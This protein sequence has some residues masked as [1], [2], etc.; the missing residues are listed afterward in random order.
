MKPENKQA[1]PNQNEFNRD[2]S[3]QQPSSPTSK[4]GWT[5][6]TAGHATNVP[7]QQRP[8]GNTGKTTPTGSSQGSINKDKYKD[9]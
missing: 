9:K 1:Q 6:G 5:G 7:G 3:K 2:K 4:G 8:Q